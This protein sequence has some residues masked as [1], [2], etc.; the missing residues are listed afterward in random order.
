MGVQALILARQVLYGLCYLLNPMERKIDTLGFNI[1]QLN[2]IRLTLKDQFA[3]Y[4]Q[5][6]IQF[7]SLQ[8]W[9]QKVFGIKIVHV[10]SLIQTDGWRAAWPISLNSSLSVEEKLKGVL[11]KV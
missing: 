7:E 3:F 9:S 8:Y 5:G 4:L 10:G 6:N 1:L 2:R 11:N